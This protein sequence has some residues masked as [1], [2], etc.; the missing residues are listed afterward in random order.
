M[1]SR[2]ELKQQDNKLCGYIST[3]F[4]SYCQTTMICCDISTL[5]Q[6]HCQT[7][8]CC[9]RSSYLEFTRC[10]FSEYVFSYI[11]KYPSLPNPMFDLHKAMYKIR[12]FE[13]YQHRAWDMEE[14]KGKLPAGKITSVKRLTTK[15]RILLAVNA[16]KTVK[17]PQMKKIMRAVV[18]IQSRHFKKWF[19]T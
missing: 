10:Y 15:I 6:S 9:C 11:V 18:T 17:I 16:N 8:M 1:N 2:Y 3:L 19:E 4:Q 14:A 12:D 7:T 13:N 5:F